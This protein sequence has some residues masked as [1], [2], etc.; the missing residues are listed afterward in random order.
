MQVTLSG[1][2]T[3]AVQ[4]EI[5]AGR[6]ASV[7]EAVE[8]MLLAWADQPESAYWERLAREVDEAS[9]EAD[10]GQWVE[11]TPAFFESLREL[12]RAKHRA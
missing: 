5:E 8:G 1:R 3:E 10:A 12:V 11:A 6:F 9:A 4:R 7:E 2:A